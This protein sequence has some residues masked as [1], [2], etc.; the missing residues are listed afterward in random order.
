MPPQSDDA[1]VAV[2][3]GCGGKNPA[4][5]HECDWCG[6]PF[7]SQGGRIRLTFWQILSSLMFIGLIVAVAAL[8]YLN[9]GRPLPA[10]AAAPTSTPPATLVPTLAVTPRVTATVAVT[11]AR[12]VAAPTATDVPTPAPTP[13]PSPIVARIANT[14]GLGV[15]VR[16]EP[17]PRPVARACYGR[18]RGCS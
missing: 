8:A 7:V 5:A 4:G 18:A 10:R 1:S 2:C 6:R 17:G 12:A 9:A 16:A 15:T 14:S 3:P 13:T 11:T